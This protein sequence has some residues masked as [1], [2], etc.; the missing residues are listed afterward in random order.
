MVMRSF[1]IVGAAVGVLACSLAIPASA[2]LALR[3]KV[4]TTQEIVVTANPLATAAGVRVLREGG[5]AVDAAIA[6]QA[7]LGL[8]E[9]Q[10]TGIGGGGFLVHFNA[11]TRAVRTWDARE[12]APA[13][14]DGAYFL[15]ADGKPRGFNEAVNSGRS[16][17]VPG[18]PALWEAV[19]PLGALP[20]AQS[21]APAVEAAEAGFAMS[22]RLAAAVDASKA[23]LAHDPAAR[24]YFLQPD[25]AGKPAGTVLRNPEY[26]AVLRGIASGGAQSFYAGPVAEALVAAV[27]SDTRPGGAGAMTAADLQAY[28]VVER[29]PVCGPFRGHVVCGMGP[30][31]SGGIA[32]LQ[33]LG[34]LEARGALP[35]PNPADPLAVDVQTVHQFLQANR[36]AF[37][38]RAVYLA[39]PAFVP[40]PVAG[41]VD[42]GYL[43]SRAATITT[44]AIAPGL[45]V[46]GRPP[47]V[48]AGG[49]PDAS[50]PR[51]GGTSHASIV[52]RN[53]HAVSMTTTVESGFGNGVMV[54][55]FVL[56]NELTDFSFDPGPADAPV[57]NRV[58]GGKRPRSS[59]AP[60]MV[61]TPAGQLAFLAGSPG[62]ASIIGT[63]SKSLLA[64]MAYGLDPQQAANQPH[65]Q[66]NNTPG[67]TLESLFTDPPPG[68]T[69]LLGP[70]DVRSLRDQLTA[71]G[72]TVSPSA[73]VLTSGLSLVRV[74]PGGFEGGADPRREGV[75]AGR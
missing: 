39:D 43:A 75:A 6:V 45:A 34:M 64:M 68:S 69:G 23:F 58:Q 73:T 20:L 66:N 8:V 31:S 12:M 47:A 5:N 30:P 37:A 10:A 41:L 11:Q 21:L 49:T 36:L 3:E 19:K 61:F 71:L 62:G 65:F 52:D 38:D 33:I 27:R 2:Q 35:P 15:G 55:G 29:T 18:I 51:F 14:A 59:M 72:W 25:G 13:G 7:M 46:A 60:T 32:V 70:F 42:G 4:S 67:T 54:H 28:R 26:A 50:P 63:V 24:A 1:V 44:G 22:P 74:V 56:N 17:G 9:P 16:V 40:V 57:A 53:G 48:G